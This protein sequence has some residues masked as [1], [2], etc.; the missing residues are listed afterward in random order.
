MTGLLSPLV[1]WRVL[2]IR[3]KCRKTVYEALVGPA[4]AQGSSKRTEDCR[5]ERQDEPQ[6]RQLKNNHPRSLRRPAAPAPGSRAAAPKE[7]SSAPER[8]GLGARATS[9]GV[10]P[11]IQA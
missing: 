10:R 2:Q 6:S 4:G 5:K 1:Q 8:T 3:E 7:P 11:A 9:W